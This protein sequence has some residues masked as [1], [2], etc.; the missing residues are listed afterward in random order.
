MSKVQSPMSKAT[1][2]EP[3]S[4]GLQTDKGQRSRYP[5]AKATPDQYSLCFFLDFGLLDFGLLDLGLLDLGLGFLLVRQSHAID[6]GVI[7]FNIFGRGFRAVSFQGKT[8]FAHI[9]REPK[10]EFTGFAG[11]ARIEFMK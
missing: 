2:A 1:G 6:C 7:D 4:R 3:A 10:Y 11:D 5:S 8:V 9:R